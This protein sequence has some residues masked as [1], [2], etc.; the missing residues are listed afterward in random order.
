MVLLCHFSLPNALLEKLPLQLT[1][2]GYIGVELFFVISG[3]VVTRSLQKNNYNLPKFI[4][5]RIFRLYPAL[6]L[7]IASAW[8]VR[9][10]A[11]FYSDTLFIQQLFGGD[12]VNY[13]AQSFGVLT[14]TLI[15]ITN[16]TSYSFGALWSLS[17]EF[18]FYTTLALL[19]CVARYMPNY[20][21]FAPW[22][23]IFGS[24]VVVLSVINHRLFNGSEAGLFINYLAAH[25]FEFIAA[26]VITAYIPSHAVNIVRAFARPRHVPALFCFH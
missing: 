4:C 18:Q 15:N 1:N 3:F 22:M 2:P 14:G 20:S 21:V 25:K 24:G 19:L 13:A 10:L 17:V 26:G 9:G 7:F 11:S 23:L 6:I 12:I 5:S 16:S 8:L